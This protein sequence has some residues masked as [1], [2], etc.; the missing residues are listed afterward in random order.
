MMV[1]ADAAGLRLTLATVAA[2][3]RDEVDA[4]LEVLGLIDLK[5]KIVTR[6]GSLTAKLKRA[7]WD[8]EFMRKLLSQ[9]R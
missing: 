4:A 2:E 5:G 1:S 9:M 3:D 8:D 7:G 6:K